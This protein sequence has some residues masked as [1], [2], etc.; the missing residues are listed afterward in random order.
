V[1]RYGPR[2]SKS[3][4]YSEKGRLNVEVKFAP[5]SCTTRRAPMRVGYLRIPYFLVPSAF[6]HLTLSKQEAED[7]AVGLLVHQA[8]APAVRLELYPKAS[9]DVF[10]FVIEGENREI[11]GSA[12][13]TCAASA[14][15]VAGAAL[16][17]SGV[18]MLGLVV[19][20]TAVSLFLIQL[21]PPIGD[22]FA[23]VGQGNGARWNMA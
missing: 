5:F 1:I 9:L 12:S 7:R 19:S 3:A 20:C 15:V 14:A 17:H 8:L 13:A 11:G 4:T 6:I 18:D 16:A 22:N 21:K 2:Q 23:S 10:I